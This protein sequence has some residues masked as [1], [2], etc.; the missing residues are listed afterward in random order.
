MEKCGHQK[1]SRKFS[2]TAKHKNAKFFKTFLRVKI[3]MI[4][5]VRF[6]SFIQL[7]INN[8][9]KPSNLVSVFTVHMVYLCA[10]AHSEIF[11]KNARELGVGRRQFHPGINGLKCL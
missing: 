10:F 6:P 2:F 5:R 1:V 8:V 11:Q 4:V 9:L 7:Q 3:L